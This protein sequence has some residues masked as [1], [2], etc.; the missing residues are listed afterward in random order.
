MITDSLKGLGCKLDEQSH[1]ELKV[2]LL[3]AIAVER[4]ATAE[5]IAY[6]SAYESRGLYLREGYSSLYSFLTQGH[7]YSE[8]AAA[9]RCTVARFVQKYPGVLTQL[10]QGKLSLT[11]ADVVARAVTRGDLRDEQVITTIM[12]VVGKSKAEA[13]LEISKLCNRVVPSGPRET[14]RAIT[15]EASV[16][17]SSSAVPASTQTGFRFLE[18]YDSQS[19]AS[20]GESHAEKPQ[21]LEPQSAEPQSAEPQS[22]EP[23]SADPNPQVHVQEF[24][25]SLR[26]S[27]EAMTD[28]RRAQEI[29]GTCDLATTI[30]KLSHF[31]TS[32]RDPLKAKPKKDVE[33]C[34]GQGR[35]TSDASVFI[36]TVQGAPASEL[37]VLESTALESTASELAPSGSVV[38]EPTAQKFCPRESKFIPISL[39]SPD[40]VAKGVAPHSADQ[41]KRSRYIPVV[42]RR[43]VFQRA[44]GQCCYVDQ[45]TGR[46]CGERRWLEVDHI[47]PFSCGGEHSPENLQVLCRSHNMMRARDVFGS[48][49]IEQSMGLKRM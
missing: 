7:G 8:G 26:L 39:A 22:A 27:N 23:Q 43:A 40:S 47:K 11:V 30:E 34:T 12:S 28:L 37:T 29:L 2:N 46:R 13:E 18:D 3:R 9:R 24:K 41:T 21:T 44:G 19:E 25:I 35:V 1:A 15:T 4:H 6:L 16:S 36:S 33:V 10:S 14:V 17:V 45:A 48:E 5:V 49:K 20:P 31:Y 32:R 42:L 38:P